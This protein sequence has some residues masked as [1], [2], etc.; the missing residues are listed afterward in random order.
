MMSKI[1]CVKYLY[2][3]RCVCG[4]LSKKEKGKTEMERFHRIITNAGKVREDV[5]SCVLL[6]S[7]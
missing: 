1:E 5:L 3:D 6:Y 2:V 7:S 4:C